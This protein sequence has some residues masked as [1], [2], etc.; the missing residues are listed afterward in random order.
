MTEYVGPVDVVTIDGDLTDPG[1]GTAE[2]RG[3][4]DEGPIDL[5]TVEPGAADH[6]LG[7]AA[8]VVISAPAR[9]TRPA[10]SE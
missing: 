3:I 10:L 9:L 1:T 6:G 5:R 4:G 7:G 2:G 8:A